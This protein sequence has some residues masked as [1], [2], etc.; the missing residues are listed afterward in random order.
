MVT[1]DAST[2]AGSA[3]STVTDATGLTKATQKTSWLVVNESP[4]SH[5]MSLIPFNRRIKDLIGNTAPPNTDGGVPI[6]LSFHTKG[7]CYS[8]CR[9]KNNHSHVLTVA[10]KERLGN[11][12]ADRLEKL[13]KP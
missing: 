6:C 7:R 13:S 5:L 9:H 1:D 12:I 11:Y 4:D 8:N 2:V 3:M 10:E